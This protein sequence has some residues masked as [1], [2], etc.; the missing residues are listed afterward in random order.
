MRVFDIYL[1]EGN[2]FLH[3]L[4]LAILDHLSH[5]ILLQTFSF[6]SQLAHFFEYVSY[7][8]DEL[9]HAACSFELT[10]DDLSEFATSFFE[11]EQYLSLVSENQQP[12]LKS[13]RKCA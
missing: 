7:S 3:K 12:S 9:V 4:A 1:V 2:L 13:S 11:S 10:Q 6:G 5:E 8:P